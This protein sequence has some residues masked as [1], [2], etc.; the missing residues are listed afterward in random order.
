MDTLDIRSN[1]F[2]TSPLWWMPHFKGLDGILIDKRLFL[3][4][5]RDCLLFLSG[6]TLEWHS[7]NPLGVSTLPF[8]SCPS[9][10]L[11]RNR[12][13]L[14]PPWLRPFYV[15]PS[16]SLAGPLSLS[17]SLPRVEEC[18]SQVKVKDVAGLHVSEAV[19][20]RGRFLARKL[21]SE[22][23][24]K[25][26]WRI[27][28][29]S[30]QRR[31]REVREREGRKKKNE[32]CIF[33]IHSSAPYHRSS[34][35]TYTFYTM[36]ALS[37]STTTSSSSVSFCSSTVKRRKTGGDGGGGGC[38]SIGT[39]LSRSAPQ[40]A[41][42]GQ[43]DRIPTSIVGVIFSFLPMTDHF[44]TAGTCLLLR[45]ISRDDPT[46]MNVNMGIMEEEGRT[47]SVRS[48]RLNR[49]LERFSFR[50]S[51]MNGIVSAG[52][53]N[54]I[55]SIR[56]ME[57]DMCGTNGEDS[58]WERIQLLLSLKHVQCL[59]LSSLDHNRQPFASLSSLQKFT[60]L[61]TLDRIT[62]TDMQL[63]CLPLSLS[64]LTA[65]ITPTHTRDKDI[66][67]APLQPH[68]HAW[69]H[70]VSLPLLHTLELSIYWEWNLSWYASL[71]SL[72]ALEKLYIQEK[73]DHIRTSS[74][75]FLSLLASSSSSSSSS[76]AIVLPSIRSL[77]Y[78][79]VSD[80][81]V[82]IPE[83]L[84]NCT[85]LDL[86]SRLSTGK[87]VEYPKLVRLLLRRPCNFP[88][89]SLSSLA[90]IDLPTGLTT[91][92]WSF[93]FSSL[94]PLLPR[95]GSITHLTLVDTHL[96]EAQLKL[97]AKAIPLLQY[98]HL[99]NGLIP[100]TQF[101]VWATHFP[102]LRQWH[103]TNLDF[104]YPPL[105]SLSNLGLFATRTALTHFSLDY[106]S[107][108]PQTS[109]LSSERVPLTQANLA[110]LRSYL[111]SSLV[112]LSLRG[113]AFTPA[114]AD[115]VF[116]TWLTHPTLS[117][118]PRLILSPQWSRNA[119]QLDTLRNAGTVVHIDTL[120]WRP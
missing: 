37:S 99:K 11:G 62:L 27:L 103:G 69:R 111:P 85:S 66:Q 31:E 49:R 116:T 93:G 109:S 81:V 18:I 91:L 36:A 94:Q 44:S 53:W 10:Y 100:Y 52:W 40:E 13:T 108:R 54:S 41:R 73:T 29:V 15:T 114:I 33:F 46:L 67:V 79:S 87:C 12:F 7:S 84:P 39:R 78:D 64:I 90:P 101:G 25:K 35:T 55:S 107:R 115:K 102:R 9:L 119:H 118:F 72:T 50:W 42:M 24:K 32:I 3:H 45:H 92:L 82:C 26:N 8:F 96:E 17:C 51:M 20:M 112:E 106:C 80:K 47:R 105:L 19:Q 59:Y 110:L 60:S 58:V 23:K 68:Y 95:L 70:L 57:I 63:E 43:L 98:I 89:P 76:T 86:C 77:R 88:T 104:V 61:T 83:L 74:S 113:V 97:L 4:F 56:I 48:L 30:V 14:H 16:L 28:M 5:F 22:N 71:S 120:P 75:L 34:N 21:G 2:I 38:K 1:H 65:T 117:P 6:C